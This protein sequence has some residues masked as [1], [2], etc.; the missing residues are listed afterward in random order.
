M[1]F[2]TMKT[3]DGKRA[4]ES[5]WWGGS[6]AQSGH[7]PPN[8]DP[9]DW[10][11]VR[12]RLAEGRSGPP[13]ARTASARALGQG[14]LQH[15]GSSEGL[16][17][18]GEHTRGWAELPPCAPLSPS[19]CRSTWP[20]SRTAWPERH[21]PRG[22]LWSLGPARWSGS[23]AWQFPHTDPCMQ[24]LCAGRAHGF[25]RSWWPC[26]GRR[27]Y[28]RDPMARERGSFPAIP[29]EACPEQPGASGESRGGRAWG[30]DRSC[31]EV[32]LPQPG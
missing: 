22:R 30:G 29:P 7:I 27:S 23:Y 26:R 20:C 24:M 14:S 25:Q 12:G 10:R 16:G 3:R 8:S 13:A 21:L 32:A 15:P 28:R 31:V 6:R 5:S 18:A 19:P 2:S 11:A 1:Y 4:G 17:G 9:G